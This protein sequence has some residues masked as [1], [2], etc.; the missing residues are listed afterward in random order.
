ME[1][2]FPNLVDCKEYCFKKLKTI[3]FSK[4]FFLCQLT[5]EGIYGVFTLGSKEFF[6]IIQFSKRAMRENVDNNEELLTSLVQ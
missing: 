2:F 1:R 6:G 5:L 3:V 4:N